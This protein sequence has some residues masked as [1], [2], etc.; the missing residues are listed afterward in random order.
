MKKRR[1][2]KQPVP[3]A[4]IMVVE[5]N[6]EPA[7]YIEVGGHRIAKRGY[8]GTPQAMSWISL[9]PEWAVRDHNY[10]HGIEIEYVPIGATQ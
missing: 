6:G 10:P 9:D 2:H 1:R 4:H 5:E 3:E 7:I 8:P